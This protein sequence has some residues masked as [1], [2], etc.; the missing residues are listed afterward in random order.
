M[1]QPDE[2]RELCREKALKLLEARPHSVAE[3][4]RKLINARKFTRDHIEQ[5]IADLLRLDILNDQH[6][7][8][9]MVDYLKTTN[10]GQTK[11][12]FKL[13]QKGLDRQL[14]QNTIKELWNEGEDNDRTRALNAAEIKWK[15]LRKRDEPDFK[16]R[17]LLARFLASRG[18][19]SNAIGSAIR[20]IADNTQD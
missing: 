9:A 4:R 17:Q 16:K 8:E 12:T 10:I 6:F 5:V 19:A 14:V 11:A 3:I 1:T 18:F 15:T 7:A 20:K 13:I 2:Q